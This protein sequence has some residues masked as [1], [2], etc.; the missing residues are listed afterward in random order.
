MCKVTITFIITLEKCKANI[1][2]INLESQYYFHENII[3]PVHKKYKMTTELT[4]KNHRGGN[5]FNI[6]H[7]SILHTTQ[8]NT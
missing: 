2:F 8:R 7:N 5:T 1:A 3:T 4:H 6:Y